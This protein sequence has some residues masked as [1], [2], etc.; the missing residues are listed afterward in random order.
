MFAIMIAHPV[1]LKIKRVANIKRGTFWVLVCFQPYSW[2]GPKRCSSNTSVH[3]ERQTLAM[4]RHSLTASEELPSRVAPVA[5][6][7]QQYEEESWH[8]AF[9][10]TITGT[11]LLQVDQLYQNCNNL[12]TR[13]QKLS[14]ARHFSTLSRTNASNTQKKKKSKGSSL[15]YLHCIH[16]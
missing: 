3:A 12:K 2:N 16:C 6:Q 11:L 5:S 15:S 8:C 1:N 7:E 4:Q 10:S 9:G 13:V 14:S